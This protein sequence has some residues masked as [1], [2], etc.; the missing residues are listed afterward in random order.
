MVTRN[1]SQQKK[2]TMTDIARDANVS[3]TTVSFVLNDNRDVAISDETRNRV[4]KS[5][6]NLGYEHRFASN[7]GNKMKSQTP[8]FGFLVDEIATSVF[9]SI[10]I[11]GAQQTAWSSG[12]LM[13]LATSHNDPNYEQSI[14]SKWIDEGVAGV[15]YASILTRRVSPPSSLQSVNTVLLNCYTDSNLYTSIVPAE[16]LGGYAATE[17]LILSGCKRIAFI[18]GEEWMEAANDR[19]LGYQ[20]ALS[21]YSLE[22]HQSLI[23]SGNFL[24]SGGYQAT[25]A[26]LNE[27]NIPDGIF[28]AN[29]LMAIGAYEAIK[30][31]GLSIPD[32]IAVIGYD[33]QEIASHL[34]PPLSTVLLPHR[35]MGQWAIDQLL[36]M[37]NSK[38]QPRLIKI[39]CPL[40]SR[41][42]VK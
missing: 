19:L 6:K 9:A 12:Y 20:N 24:P 25:K 5:A 7:I 21:S 37:Q 27:T 14:L 4:L 23:R 34:N 38:P 13:Q 39:D 42:S 15:I 2:I 3:Q 31:A 30:E 10:S 1:S 26:L 28:C 17:S 8:F 32:D 36:S 29:D 40:I 11:D 16:S 41:A 22:K 35:E 18:G 33:D